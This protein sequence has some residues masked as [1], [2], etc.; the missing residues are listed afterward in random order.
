MDEFSKILEKVNENV[1]GISEE[2]LE[3]VVSVYSKIDEE[4]G[5]NFFLK[6]VLESICWTAETTKETSKVEKVMESFLLP[7]LLKIFNKYD[8][9]ILKQVFMEIEATIMNVTDPEKTRKYIR[10]LN[11]GYI[12]RLLKFWQDFPINGNIALKQKILAILDLRVDQIEEFNFYLPR[13]SRRHIPLEKKLEMMNLMVDILDSNKKEYISYLLERKIDE[14]K[15]EVEKRLRTRLNKFYSLRCGIKFL[16]DMSKDKN[17]ELIFKKQLE[18]RSV[19][20]WLMEDRV[21][22][23]VLKEMEENGFNSEL[24]L[25]TKDFRVQKKSDGMFSEDWKN[26]FRKLVVKI[27]GSKKNEI[28]PKISIPNHS[29]G[30]V[31]SKI[32]TDY[33][34]AVERE[35]EDAALRVLS[36]LENL[37]VKAYEGKYTPRSVEETLMEIRGL[38]MMIEKGIPFTFKGAKVFARVWKRKVP[39]DFYDSNLLWC[40][41]FLPQGERGE[42]PLLFLDPKTT[43]LQFFTQGI[44]NPIGVAF[45]YAGKVEEEPVIFVDSWEGGPFIYSVLGQ[46]KTKEFALEAMKKFARKCGAK[47]LVVFAN[48]SYSRGKEFRNFLKK[49]YEATKVDFLAIDVEDRMLKEYSLGNKH[50]T[51]DAFGINKPLKGTVET[52]VFRV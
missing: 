39:D 6:E 36:Y 2:L 18:F 51:T 33:F 19:R 34:S 32:K 46:D 23:M 29:P 45:L 14:L 37:I 30:S 35:E 52:L 47:E 41:W 12:S 31:F 50:H 49:K 40:C 9:E 44:E 24:F 5:T 8:G 48:A 4:R 43:L 21:S 28:L 15:K 27:V 22:K 16:G 17:V 25:G 20:K 11:N 7:D 26:A 3:K 10:W 1:K 38:R 13:I 42:I